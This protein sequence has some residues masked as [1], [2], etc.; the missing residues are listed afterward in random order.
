MNLR[1]CLLQIN[2]YNKLFEAVE[3]LRKE[4]FDPENEKHETMLLKVIDLKSDISHE[5][6]LSFRVFQF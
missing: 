2:G 5:D 3:E 4:V 6:D 1:Q